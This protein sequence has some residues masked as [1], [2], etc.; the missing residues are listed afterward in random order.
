[1]KSNSKKTDGIKESSKLAVKFANT[2]FMLGIL[3]FALVVMY[4]AFRMIILN[5]YFDP[6]YGSFLL[7]ALITAILL[8]LGLMKL[9]DE[10][11]VNISVLFITVVITVYAFEF[12]LSMAN[13]MPDTRSKMEVIDDLIDS[14]KNA[15]PNFLPYYLLKSNRFNTSKGRIFPL[16]GISNITTILSNEPGYIPVIETDEYGFNN[17][18]GLYELNKVDIVLTGDS[19]TEGY[20]VYADET[21]SAV[22]RKMGFNAISVG[23]GGNGP[24][25]ELAAVKEYI[26]QLKP[27]IVL[28]MYAVNDMKNL[29]SEM[30]S[31]FLQKYLNEDDFSQNL[32]S[33]QEEI[34]SLLVDYV[35]V[36]WEK[37]REKERERIIGHIKLNNL[38]KRINLITPPPPTHPTP[39]THL[40][41]IL[42]NSK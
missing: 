40:K 25:I 39:K 1:M 36:E 16:G 24:L 2:V 15:Y 8:F 37:E 31:S 19:Y 5:E 32:I 12:Y 3:F 28:W 30:E 7:F 23:K 17:P 35:E 41:I 11:K 34:D 22:L 29:N 6:M 18:K 42:K 21:I 13:D 38:R 10:L 33:R 4:A 14:G 27:K 9:G 26:E 20:T